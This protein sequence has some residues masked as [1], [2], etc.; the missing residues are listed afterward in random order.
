MSKV[1]LICA[2]L[3][4]PLIACGSSHKTVKEE[5]P[6]ITYEAPP[7][8]P[9]REEPLEGE[10]KEAALTL[11]R[12]HFAYNSAEVAPAARTA[13]VDAAGPLVRNPDV[14]LYIDGHADVRGS[15]EYNRELG[16]RRAQAVADVLASLGVARDRLHIES[17][18]KDQLLVSGDSTYANAQNRRVDFRLM[19]GDV[20]LVLE[21]GV[22]LDDQGEVL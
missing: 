3:V 1:I 20:N 6:A 18:G 5:P 4:V 9:P 17:F 12:V 2:S 15:E 21:E 7:A 19:R 11:T 14:H 16:E 13:L 8:P 10:L 22:L